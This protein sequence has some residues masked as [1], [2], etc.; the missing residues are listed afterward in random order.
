[1]AKESLPLKLKVT[2]MPGCS[3]SKRSP[4]S[5]KL[6]F[7]EAAAKTVTVPPELPSSP[8]DAEQA[9]SPREARS[10]SAARRRAERIIR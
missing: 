2:S 10:T 9:P 7:S 6:S 8:S 4:S 3:S 5:V 1:M